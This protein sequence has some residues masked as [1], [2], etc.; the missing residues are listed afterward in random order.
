MSNIKLNFHNNSG[1]QTNR[2]VVIFKQIIAENFGKT[3]VAWKVIMNCGIGEY[4]PFVYS[5]D[6]QISANTSDVN[7]TPLLTASTGKAYDFVESASGNTLQ[8]SSI[9]AT[10]KQGVEIRNHLSHSSMSANCFLDGRLL[11]T[12]TNIAPGQVAV[13]QSNSLIYVGT[14][15]GIV[16]GDMLNASTISHCHFLNL[17]GVASAEILM[18]GAGPS[19]N[20]TLENVRGS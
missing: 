1:D 6:F 7:F 14:V 13:F 17:L 20:F 11:A 18:V 15:S 4:H 5:P 12:K 2:D 16:E 9:P 10:S 3:A 19:F 8:L